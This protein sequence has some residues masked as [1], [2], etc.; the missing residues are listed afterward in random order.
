MAEAYNIM[1]LNVVFSD[2]M[3]SKPRPA[4]ILSLDN[5]QIA[6]YRIT[7]KYANKS[8]WI[9]AKYFKIIDYIEAGLREQSYIDTIEV[10]DID[11]AETNF[12][13]I[14]QLTVRDRERLIEFL[15]E[16]SLDNQ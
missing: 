14:G 13:I 12:R 8:E 7:T 6:F 9:K 1:A 4:L 3:G 15:S 16:Q 5:E 10:L 2:V 11:V